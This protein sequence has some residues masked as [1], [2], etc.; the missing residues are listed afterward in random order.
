MRRI[1]PE[2]IEQV[3]SANDIVDIIGEDTVLKKSGSRYIGLCPFPSHD[4]KTPSFSVSSDKQLY[5]C[6]GCGQSGNIY[7][8]LQ[9]RK[10]FRFIEAIEFLAERAGL[11][12]PK[13]STQF[14]GKDYEEKRELF[15]MNSLICCWFEN[16]LQLQPSTHSVKKYFHKRGFSEG[17]VKAFR[18][19]YVGSAWDGLCS[20]LR[21]EGISL[22]KAVQL[23][24]VKKTGNRFYDLFRNRL[25]FPIFSRNGKDVLGFGARALDDQMPKYIN[26]ADSRI[27][28]KGKTFYG[29]EKSSSMIRKLDQAVVV[30]GYTDFISLYQEGIKNVVATLGT[31]LTSDHARWLSWHTDKVILSFDGDVAGERAM[32]R[33]LNILLSF[34]LIP[35]ALSLEKDL[36][37]DTFIRK[38]GKAALQKR[39]DQA[40]DLFLKRLMSELNN[41]AHGIDKFSLIK[42]MVEI[43]AYTKNEMLRNYYTKRL[44][45]V[46]GSDA[47][48]ARKAL[49]KAL[50]KKKINDKEPELKKSHMDSFSSVSVSEEKISL[51][52][53]PKSELYL[54]V[55]ALQNPEYYGQIQQSH[56]IERISHA[57][58]IQMFHLLDKFDTQSRGG[59][60]HFDTWVDI[61]L[62]RVQE[63]K[64]LQKDNY[65]S[66]EH[67]SSKK[68][69]IFIQDCVNKVEREQ[70][71]LQLKTITMQL[72]SNIDNQDQYLRKI[73]EL[74]K[75]PVVDGEIKHGK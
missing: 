37:P 47:D 28:H 3:R 16:Q 19:G 2:F 66:L 8:Y 63:P 64:L 23:G 70:K 20:Y 69:K 50:Q 17:T 4:E 67:L 22:E 58:V 31:A 42:K 68:I 61:L 75:K 46:F 15:E 33:S 49:T 25:I 6:F 27:F 55:L 60:K 10:G 32:D 59:V 14:M 1:P 41:S 9:T 34:G 11:A 24:I 12:L 13:S 26:S 7:T 48:I 18:L 43:L 39:I 29:W 74:T 72:R 51:Q 5:H 38:K 52:N 45:D 53:A 65:P 57:G 73:V 30:E 44:L 21:K 35:K 40:E 62:S 36:D 54:L 56:V 71:R